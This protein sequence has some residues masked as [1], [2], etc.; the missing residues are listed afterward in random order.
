MSGQ[1]SWGDPLWGQGHTSSGPESLGQPSGLLSP[2]VEL[3]FAQCPMSVAGRAGGKGEAAVCRPQTHGDEMGAGGCSSALRKTLSPSG[4][5]SSSAV[6]S[7]LRFREARA[8]QVC[9]EAWV[10]LL[11]KWECGY[12]SPRFHKLMMHFYTVTRDSLGTGRTSISCLVQR[13]SLTLPDR[14]IDP[15]PRSTGGHCLGT[16]PPPGWASCLLSTSSSLPVSKRCCFPSSGSGRA[17]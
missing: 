5:P 6:P 1:L 7:L 12:C 14:D 10:F 2:W 3:R 16:C 4:F 9:P 15:D 11:I 8:G 17:V 13:R